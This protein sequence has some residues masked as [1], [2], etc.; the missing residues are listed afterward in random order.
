MLS[1]LDFHSQRGR[2]RFADVSRRFRDLEAGLFHGG[3]LFGRGALAA[4]DDRA[5][6]AHTASGRRCLSGDEPHHRLLHVHPDEL[7]GDLLRVATD[8]PNHDHG[9][10]LRIAVKQIERVDK[11]RADNRVAANADRRRLP[12]SALGQLMHRFVSQRPGARHDPD[13]ALF[14]TSGTGGGATTTFDMSFAQL[15]YLFND[16]MTFVAGDMLLPLGTYT[17]RSAGWLNK[18]PDDP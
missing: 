17:E 8:F 2:E 18:L 7:R 12:D 13:I 1:A 3:H 11:I 10:G 9:F 6:V 5:G 4:G 16:Y 14:A 15:D